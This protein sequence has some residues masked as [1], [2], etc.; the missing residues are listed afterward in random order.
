[1]AT[2]K[3]VRG[4][5]NEL[6]IECFRMSSEDVDDLREFLSASEGIEH[7][8]ES[9]GGRKAAPGAEIGALLIAELPAFF[10]GYAAGKAL[11]YVVDEITEWIRKRRKRPH[12]I[13]LDLN[14]RKK[15]IGKG[16]L[17]RRRD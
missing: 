11:D 13:V 17:S 7:I 3:K 9:S 4:A 5:D 16:K 8:S 2:K 15:R 12:L 6:Y 1:M 14:G 10:V